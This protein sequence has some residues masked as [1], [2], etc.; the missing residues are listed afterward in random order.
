MSGI[1]TVHLPSDSA[2]P[3][4][5]RLHFPSPSSS[6]PAPLNF[7]AFSSSA[8]RIFRLELTFLHQHAQINWNGFLSSWHSINQDNHLEIKLTDK[9]IFKLNGKIINVNVPEPLTSPM[10]YKLIF[11]ESA[12]PDSDWYDLITDPEILNS[13]QS[14]PPTWQQPLIS[15]EPLI[16]NPHPQQHIS[17]SQLDYFVYDF[18][19]FTQLQISSGLPLPKVKKLIQKSRKFNFSS[20]FSAIFKPSL[21]LPVVHNSTKKQDVNTRILGSLVISAFIVYLAILLHLSKMTSIRKKP[22]TTTIT[23][24]RLTP[25]DPSTLSQSQSQSQ[26]R[27]LSQSQLKLPTTVNPFKSPSRTILI[28]LPDAPLFKSSLSLS[29]SGSVLKVSVPAAFS[30]ADNRHILFPSKLRK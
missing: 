30:L 25:K 7:E 13:L 11:D 3:I 2:T 28:D 8:Q 10:A 21:N 16:N 29:N 15:L 23:S 27:S 1:K 22:I 20:F 24:E 26:S 9:P 17:L 6:H 18:Q 12:V 14:T 5:I 19:S 4:N